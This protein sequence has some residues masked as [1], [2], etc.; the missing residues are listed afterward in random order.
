MDLDGPTYLDVDGDRL[1]CVGIVSCL[2]V[3]SSI[4][5]LRIQDDRQ[6]KESL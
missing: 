4:E 3:L 1:C 5:T 2:V 6:L